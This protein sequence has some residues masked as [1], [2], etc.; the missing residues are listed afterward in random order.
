M[1][2]NIFSILS[3]KSIKNK[4][5]Y[6]ER[7]ALSN[8]FENGESGFNS[9]GGSNLHNC[10]SLLNTMNKLVSGKVTALG[11]GGAG[12]GKSKKDLLLEATLSPLA[13]QSNKKHLDYPDE[14]GGKESQ[15]SAVGMR[16]RPKTPASLRQAQSNKRASFKQNT[17]LQ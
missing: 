4:K 14:R 17:Q 6:I 3:H 10:K 8:N 12:N 7:Y 9:P 11:S 15:T 16:Q 2:E 5:E 13:N 1:L